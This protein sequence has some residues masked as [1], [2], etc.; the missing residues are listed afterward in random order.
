MFRCRAFRYTL[1]LALIL[2]CTNTFSSTTSEVKSGLDV[3]SEKNFAILKGKKVALV[4]NR[5]AISQNGTHL[6]DLLSAHNISVKKI[7][8]PEHGFSVDKDEKVGNSTIK[9]IPVISLYGKKR[10]LDPA[11]LSDVDIVI[12]DILG[13]G[14]RYY[15]YTA[16]MVYTMQAVAKAGK[17]MILLDRPNPSGAL[18]ISG[19][20]PEEGLSGFFTSIYPI[21]IRHGMTPG[22]MALMFNTEHKIGCK[23]QVIRMKNYKRKML[24][25]DTGLG[26][27]NPSP[28]IKTEEGA[29][30]YS[31]LGWLETTNISMGRGTD[32]PFE[33]LGAP[34]IDGKALAAHLKDLPGVTIKAI[35]F[36]PTAKY[37]KHCNKLCYGIKIVMKDKHNYDG[38]RLGLE[39]FRYLRKNY[40]KEYL[41][42]SGLKTSSGVRD[43]DA[44]LKTHSTA[45]I[46]KETKAELVS[47]N[48]IREKYLLY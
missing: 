38:F 44:K 37:H 36:T 16:T 31:S 41:T 23:L 13:V 9:D 39:I 28:N 15:T 4:T 40:P 18:I 48:K 7:F 5:S 20:M 29:I 24:Y 47:F 45:E 19:F 27:T 10:K 42:F 2:I 43:L 46:L 11:A 25:S 1:L 14:A 35:S 21:P 17:K 22:E 8:T 3:L 6:M 30:L 26:W 12:Y 33:M 32:T 34:Y